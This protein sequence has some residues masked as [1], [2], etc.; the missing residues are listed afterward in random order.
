LDPKPL[1]GSS[2][3]DAGSVA[4][5]ITIVHPPI[6]EE[7]RGEYE[8]VIKVCGP[9]NL[10]EGEKA[11]LIQKLHEG[12]HEIEEWNRQLRQIKEEL[13][14]RKNGCSS[15]PQMPIIGTP[16]WD[17]AM[18]NAKEYYQNPPLAVKFKT[19]EKG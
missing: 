10:S 1:A 4:A 9:P 5:R 7:L 15:S 11:E 13:S 12:C 2:S 16:E 17:A 14:K 6:N 19:N 3:E 18:K 8:D